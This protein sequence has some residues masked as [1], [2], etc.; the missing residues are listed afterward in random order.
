MHVSCALF[1]AAERKGR[2]L[3]LWLILRWIDLPH[4]YSTNRSTW[5]NVCHLI[6]MLESE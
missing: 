2:C 3:F 6:F 1:L 4:A 5:N